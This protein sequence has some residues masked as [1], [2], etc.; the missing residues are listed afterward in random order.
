MGA[1]MQKKRA[2]PHWL[3]AVHCVGCLWLVGS[4]CQTWRS[5]SIPGL[6]LGK[7]DRQVLRQAQQDPFPSPSDVGMAKR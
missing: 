4:G 5:S 1:A 3:L 2:R 6:D 7:S